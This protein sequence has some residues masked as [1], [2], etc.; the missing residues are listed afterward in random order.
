LLK[1]IVETPDEVFA[2]KMLGDGVIIYQTDGKLY[3]PVSGEITSAFPTKHAIGIT[4]S[5]NLEVL[6]H[7]GIDTVEL[8]GKGF[9][10]YVEVGQKVDAGDLLLDADLDYIKEH[11]T[12]DC[13]VMVFTNMGPYKSFKFNNGEVKALDKIIEL[14]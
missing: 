6:L 13:L 14:D 5:D 12:S 2:Q 7:F 11:A 9:T 10:S 1:S 4:T 3:S 8:A